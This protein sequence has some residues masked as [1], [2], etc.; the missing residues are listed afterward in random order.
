M[1]QESRLCD[2]KQNSVLSRLFQSS[3]QLMSSRKKQNMYTGQLW[4]V[5]L[6]LS[7]I[8]TWIMAFAARQR[9]TAQPAE[10]CRD[11]RRVFRASAERF[12]HPGARRNTQTS[13][14]GMTV[15]QEPLGRRRARGDPGSTAG[16]TLK[17]Y[18]GYFFLSFFFLNS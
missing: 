16:R 4:H 18:P 10:K 17:V 12:R 8:T 5:S 9:E 15:D 11:G 3:L 13:T 7:G 14:I 6:V 1:T 2:S